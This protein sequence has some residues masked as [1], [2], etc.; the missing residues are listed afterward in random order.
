MAQLCGLDERCATGC[1]DLKWTKP[2]QTLPPQRLAAHYCRILMGYDPCQDIS[3]QIRVVLGFS[4]YK[5]VSVFSPRGPELFPLKPLESLWLGLKTVKKHLRER[6]HVMLDCF[7][8][9]S[10]VIHLSVMMLP[11]VHGSTYHLFYPI[12]RRQEPHSD[13]RPRAAT[14]CLFQRPASY[15]SL[16]PRGIGSVVKDHA[17]VALTIYSGAFADAPSVLFV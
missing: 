8:K 5:L 17:A 1:L 15:L 3:S 9:P 16:L 11:T 14:P 2:T 12:Q 6:Q 10:L 13:H 7:H 4:Y